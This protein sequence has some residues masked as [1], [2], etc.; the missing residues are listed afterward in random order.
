MRSKT[1]INMVTKTVACMPSWQLASIIS[2]TWTAINYSANRSNIA[3]TYGMDKNLIDGNSSIA[4][5]RSPADPLF[6]ARQKGSI[7]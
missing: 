5:E 3:T 7:I 6:S 1:G 4:V 2:P